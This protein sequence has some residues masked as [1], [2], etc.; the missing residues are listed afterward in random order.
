MQMILE[1]LETFLEQQEHEHGKGQHALAREIL[2]PLPVTSCQGRLE[3]PL[4][5]QFNEVKGTLVESRNISHPQCKSR[6]YLLCTFKNITLSSCFKASG[7]VACATTKRICGRALRR[8]R[9]YLKWLP[10]H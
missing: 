3:E 2:R 1:R 4:T 9:D 6:M 5:Q 10:F 7:P 8:Y